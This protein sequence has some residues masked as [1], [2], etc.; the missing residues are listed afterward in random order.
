MKRAT[1]HWF[2]ARSRRAM[3]HRPFFNAAT[4]KSRSFIPR[5]SNIARCIVLVA[6]VVA[7]SSTNPTSVS[8]QPAMERATVRLDW[9]ASGYHGPLFLALERGYYRDQGIDLEIFDGKGSSTTI[10]VVASGS[11]TFGLA[12]LS[13]TALG[14]ARGMPLIA[15]A[16]IIQKSPDSVI[17]LAGSGIKVPKDIEG[18]RGA[19]SPTGASDRIFP[20]FAKSAGIDMDKVIKIQ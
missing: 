17:S 19:F 18:K 7:A 20:A 6:I 14:I 10:Q 5:C 15:V 11:E 9:L 4:H 12:N 1:S 3:P 13:A 2:D 8:A 16:G